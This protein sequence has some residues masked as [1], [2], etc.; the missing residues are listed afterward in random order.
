MLDLVLFFSLNLLYTYGYYRFYFSDK[1]NHLIRVSRNTLYA[2]LGYLEKGDLLTVVVDNQKGFKQIK[3]IDS[4]DYVIT[5]EWFDRN[6]QQFNNYTPFSLSKNSTEL[7]KTI[8]CEI[9]PL[10]LDK[11]KS[12]LAFLAITY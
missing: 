3:E 9:N 7:I 4:T 8:S 1:N 10:S 11:I 5:S 2:Y 6:K 12:Q